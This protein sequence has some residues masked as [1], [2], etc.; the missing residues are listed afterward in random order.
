MKIK[1]SDKTYDV[2]KWI[3][4]IVLPATGAF[5]LTLAG[6]W[7]L[8]YGEE[9]AGTLTALNTFLGAVLMISNSQYKKANQ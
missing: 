8:P 7:G 9:I 2:L 3:A 6:I 4:L 5:Y 1:M